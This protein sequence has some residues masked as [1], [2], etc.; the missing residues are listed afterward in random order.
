MEDLPLLVLGFMVVFYYADGWKTVDRFSGVHNVASVTYPLKGD[1]FA[2]TSSLPVQRLTVISF[3]AE[4]PLH[5]EWICILFMR[6]KVKDILI[7]K[8]QFPVQFWVAEYAVASEVNS[9][10]YD[11][12]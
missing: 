10:R 4:N 3:P 11:V 9:D 8:I 2:Q 5:L 12:P 7:S 6:F 1:V